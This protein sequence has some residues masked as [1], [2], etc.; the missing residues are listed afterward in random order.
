MKTTIYGADIEIENKNYKTV[1]KILDRIEETGAIITEIK[2]DEKTIDNISEQEIES[3]KPINHLE[4]FAKQEQEIVAEGV[5]E[6]ENYLSRIIPKIEDM[7][8]YFLQGEENKGYKV[9]I[10]LL[11]GLNWLNVLLKNLDSRDMIEKE[12]FIE[13]WK[14]TI[15]ELSS[16]ME[17]KD[18]VLLNDI[19]DYELE[20][21]LK[22]YLSLVKKLNK[23]Q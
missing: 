12:N 14:D 6:A 20:P 10:D 5:A 22:E 21:R 11:E 15:T 17:Q 13:D 19:L 23:N 16:A 8:E 18:T 4:I 2:I 3:M 9:L 7:T 1:G